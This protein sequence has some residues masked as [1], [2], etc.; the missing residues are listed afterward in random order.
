VK[1]LDRPT[2]SVPLLVLLLVDAAGMD[3]ILRK[4][5]KGVFAGMDY[6]TVLRL[7]Q[8]GEYPQTINENWILG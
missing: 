1:A 8:K 4:D 7:C 5:Y 3:H 2:L 6:D